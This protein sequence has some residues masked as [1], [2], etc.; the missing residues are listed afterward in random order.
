MLDFYFAWIF[1][2]VKNVSV[3]F[4]ASH[5]Q[6]VILFVLPQ[7]ITKI[8]FQLWHIEKNLNFE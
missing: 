6:L 4:V 1:K 2:N 8:K 5:A 3:S 7:T